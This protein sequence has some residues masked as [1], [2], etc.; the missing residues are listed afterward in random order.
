[1]RWIDEADGGDAHHALVLEAQEPL[2]PAFVEYWKRILAD[3]CANPAAGW[4][5]L[6]ID[7]A[8][9]QVETDEQGHMRAVFHNGQKRAAKGLGQ[10]LLRS[11]A[12]TCL[13]PKGED[14]KSFNRRQIRWYLEQYKLLKEAART[15]DV[16]PLFHKINAIRRLR[17]GAAT[18][19]GWFDLQIETTSFGALPREDQEMLAGLDPA[20]VIPLKDLMSGVIELDERDAAQ[21]LVEALIAYKPPH[22]ETILCK[23][24]EGIEQGQRALFYDIQCPQFPHVGTTVVNDRVHKAATRLVREMSSEQGAFPGITIRLEHQGGGSWRQSLRLLGP[25]GGSHR[26]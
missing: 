12:F 22:F 20:P 3:G 2:R 25:N 23:I 5:E 16:Q 10:Y 15:E 9:R 14:N 26:G 19:Y 6:A 17:I 1:M 18:A 21:E 4:A 7:I 8:E 24:T 11:D 13:Q